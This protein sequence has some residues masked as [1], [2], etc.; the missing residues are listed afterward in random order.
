MSWIINAGTVLGRDHAALRRSAQDAYASGADAGSAWGV[1]CDG[2]GEGARSEV[3]AGLAAAYLG[4]EIRRLLGADVPVTEVPARAVAGL[5]DLY[6]AIAGAV[7]TGVH[8]PCVEEVDRDRAATFVREHLLSTAIGFC[9]R[10]EVGVLFWCGDGIAAVDD[11]LLVIDEDNR[12]SYPA[13]A[14]LGG[15]LRV[16]TKRF[17]AR[18][19]KRI[20]VASDG[21]EPELVAAAFGRRGRA[22]QRWMQCCTRD[23]H[24]RDD[25]TIVVAER[26]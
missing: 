11:E 1:V 2:C 23:G 20:A 25:A 7:V 22:L 4:G 6:A 13:Y 10:D 3:G 12:P 24:F 9:A 26:D 21:F 16:A 19:V 8:A 14:L 17:P 18:D 5:I 15:G